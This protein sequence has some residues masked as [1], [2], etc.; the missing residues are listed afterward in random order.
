MPGPESPI[1]WMG[2]ALFLLI[3]LTK[4]IVQELITLV[5]LVKKLR[6]TIGSDYSLASGKLR[7]RNARLTAR[8]LI[9]EEHK[10][11]TDTNIATK[12][13]SKR[14]KNWRDVS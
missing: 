12:K 7:R 2:P 6:A 10:K 5:V 11:P 8:K 13:H 3:A 14:G 4:L 9:V 1:L